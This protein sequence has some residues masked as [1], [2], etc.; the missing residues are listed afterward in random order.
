MRVV[1]SQQNPENRVTAP[2]FVSSNS[3]VGVQTPTLVIFKTTDCNSGGISAGYFLIDIYALYDCLS[4]LR[5]LDVVLVYRRL[6]D[7]FRVVSIRHQVTGRVRELD[8]SIR[9]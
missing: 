3:C 8:T 2:S 7:I 4:I 6:A 9:K 1:W 5:E